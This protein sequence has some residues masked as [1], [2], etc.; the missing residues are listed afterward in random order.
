MQ[1]T[2]PSKIYDTYDYTVPGCK[3]L[4]QLIVADRRLPGRSS[5]NA[6][7]HRLTF[8]KF[9]TFCFNYILER[10]NRIDPKLVKHVR[11]HHQ[12]PDE[13][14]SRR[15]CRYVIEVEVTHNDSGTKMFMPVGNLPIF[16]YY[17]DDPKSGRYDDTDTLNMYKEFCE[18]TENFEFVSELI[19]PPDFV[20]VE[21]YGSTEPKKK[22]RSRRK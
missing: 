3:G 9:D 12:Y 10:E 13:F 2:K 1:N 14:S 20:E 16:C 5:Q 22:K 4:Y 6:I 21:K 18:N 7:I 11:I 15:G 17:L 19:P 8:D